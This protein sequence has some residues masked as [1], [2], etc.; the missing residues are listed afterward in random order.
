MFFGIFDAVSRRWCVQLAAAWVSGDDEWFGGRE[1][2]V[3]WWEGADV[4]SIRSEIGGMQSEP[5][6]NSNKCLTIYWECSSKMLRVFHSFF[7]G[8]VL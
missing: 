5:D 6:R 8:V 4:S 3:V 2:D 1:I 7:D